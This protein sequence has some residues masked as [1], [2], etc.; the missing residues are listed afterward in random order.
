MTIAV[1]RPSMPEFDEYVEE[2][3]DIWSSRWLTN[4]GVK[5]RQLEAKLLEYLKV[6]NLTLFVNGHLALEALWRYLN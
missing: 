2:I 1:T 3:R 4:M 6:P 5:H